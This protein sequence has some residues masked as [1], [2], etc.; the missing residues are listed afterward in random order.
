MF[1]GH[2]PLSCLLNGKGAV[3][4][5]VP[6]SQRAWDG[7]AGTGGGQCCGR[8]RHSQPEPVS[9][10]RCCRCCRAAAGPRRRHRRLSRLDSTTAPT[11][12]VTAREHASPRREVPDTATSCRG[13]G[14]LGRGTARLRPYSACHQLRPS[15]PAAPACPLTA[16]E[17]ESRAVPTSLPCPLSPST[18]TQQTPPNPLPSA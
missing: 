10:C 12:E 11:S 6:W 17:P 7:G 15:P 13:Q 9:C 3:E 8:K 4:T 18:H 14:R 2:P 1:P 5:S 16:E